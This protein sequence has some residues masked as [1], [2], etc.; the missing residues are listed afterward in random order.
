MNA[1]ERITIIVLALFTSA[2]VIYGCKKEDKSASPQHHTPQNSNPVACFTINDSITVVYDTIYFTNCSTNDD[3]LIYYF[4]DGQASD[5]ANPK[6][7]YTTAGVYQVKLVAYNGG[8]TSVALKT[9]TV[10]Q[11]I[12]GSYTA[13]DST[14]MGSNTLTVGYCGCP[15]S[16][17]NFGIT[18]SVGFSLGFNFGQGLNFSTYT[19]MP[20]GQ[21]L[22][23]GNGS[24]STNLDTIRLNLTTVST[25]QI[26]VITE[27][28][29][30]AVYVRN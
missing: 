24:F 12:Y 20:G 22:I 27:S 2:L 4:G 5:S 15:N 1:T 23:F 26:G 3:S 10:Q 21:V 25:N 28:S 16:S 14:C 13:I 30:N 29:C 18:W 19:N 6:H 17:A 8:D 11:G 9:V 7:V